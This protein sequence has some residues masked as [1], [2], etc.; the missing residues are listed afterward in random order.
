MSAWFTM[1]TLIAFLLGVFLSAMVKSWFAK[2]KA[3][4]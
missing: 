2:A 1:H 3:K 4:V